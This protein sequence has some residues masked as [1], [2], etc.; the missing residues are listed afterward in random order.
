MLG[1][2]GQSEEHWALVDFA[3]RLDDLLCERAA[4]GADADDRRRLDALDCGDEIPGW[5]MRMR[6]GLL[7]VDE[8]GAARLEQTV[9]VEHVHP[10]LCILERHSLLDQ[11]G[12]EEIGKP[13]PC[14][15]GAR[16]S[17]S[18]RQAACP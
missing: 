7:E 12:A 14:R 9:D 18:R 11:R 10:R 2:I 4:G 5:R 17:T 16:N 15:T 1:G 8:V 13:D 6:V 3:H